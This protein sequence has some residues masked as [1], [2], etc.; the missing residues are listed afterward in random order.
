[1]FTTL[2][3]ANRAVTLCGN[4]LLSAAVSLLLSFGIPDLLYVGA[5][6]AGLAYGSNFS[7]VLAVCADAFGPRH[8]ATINGLLDLG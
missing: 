3:C 2:V 6:G 8:I 7:V 4:L 1:M 5:C